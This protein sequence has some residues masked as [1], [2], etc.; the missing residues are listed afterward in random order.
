M[1]NI[2]I[3]GIGSIGLRHF[4]AAIKIKRKLNIFLFD[5]KDTSKLKKKYTSSHHNI[6]C[7]DKLNTIPIDLDLV[8]V[9]T[10][11]DVRF[12][13]TLGII[14]KA[15]VKNIIFEKFLFQKQKDY[16]S[17]LKLLNIK[18]ISSW[19]NCPRRSQP[20]YI[21]IK[22]L[23]KNKRNC[24]MNV[25]G[26]NWNMGSNT[27][28]F[29]DLFFFLFGEKLKLKSKKD[30]LIKANS[31]KRKKFKEFFGGIRL[32]FG[33]NCNFEAI[34]K[35]EKK[36]FFN[37]SINTPQI[38]LKIKENNNQIIIKEKNKLK[39]FKNFYLSEIGSK[40]IENILK[41]K[42]PTI[43]PFKISLRHH[44]IIHKIFLEKI[45]STLKVKSKLCP[46]T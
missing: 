40:N 17:M 42:N 6:F 2:L 34:S 39:K 16:S 23:L 14:K 24:T 41:K 11:S 10:N 38:S 7:I 5:K 4:Q 32:S 31:Y 9:S 25:K 44:L 18:K 13:V 8:I 45:N 43:T 22:K 26:S 28:H 19:V 36:I 37:L 21:F 27:I 1:K 20:A 29:L 12:K 33:N 30:S 15:K 46:V 3:A 35:R